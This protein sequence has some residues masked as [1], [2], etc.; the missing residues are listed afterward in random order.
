MFIRPIDIT[1]YYKACKESEVIFNRPNYFENI[2]EDLYIQFANMDSFTLDKYIPLITGAI[3]LNTLCL[4]RDKKL[5]V[6][7]ELSK[8]WDMFQEY[9]YLSCAINNMTDVQHIINNKTSIAKLCKIL[10]NYG[11]PVTEET[12]RNQIQKRIIAVKEKSYDRKS[13]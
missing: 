4:M 2:I 7:P 13:I 12:I 11:L 10:N 5:L 1:E 6:D 3:S 9:V 8:V